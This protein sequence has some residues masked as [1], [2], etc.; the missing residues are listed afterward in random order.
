MLSYLYSQIHT[1]L[2][3][4]IKTIFGLPSLNNLCRQKQFLL[5]AF[6]TPTSSLQLFSDPRREQ[7]SALAACGEQAVWNDLQP[8]CIPGSSLNISE[9]IRKPPLFFFTKWFYADKVNLLFSFQQ[10]DE[11]DRNDFMG[12]AVCVPRVGRV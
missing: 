9:M 4:C 7:G 1:H 5:S 8:S 6:A 3:F 12:R 11:T 2:C 10:I